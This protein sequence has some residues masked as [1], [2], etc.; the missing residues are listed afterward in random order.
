MAL[1][2]VEGLSIEFQVENEWLPVV[3]D[4]SF[5]LNKGE[6]LALVGESGCGKSVTS[7]SLARLLPEPPARY[8]KGRV[9]LTTDGKKEDILTL[10]PK[11]LRHIRGKRVAYIFQEPTVSLNPVF[12]V[13]SQIA[14]AIELH[15]PEI[16]NVKSE[17]I[18]LL[19]QVGIP[20]PEARFKCYPHEMSG[21]M[22][23]RIMIAIALACQPDILV[24]DEPTTALDV[25][26]QA[27]ILELLQELRETLGMA[28]L[29]ITHN[30]GIVAEVA[31]RV[32]VMYAGK[33][34]EKATT[35]KLL[36]N[37]HHPYTK[38]LLS[39]VPKLD[40]SDHTLTTIRG[41]VPTPQ[42]FPKG[43]RFYGRCELADTLTAE[44]QQKC[45]NIV[46]HFIEVEPE[47][48]AHCHRMNSYE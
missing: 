38:A 43:C 39:A 1:I 30:L 19:E 4:V 47:H 12:T 2:Q 29:L 21:G 6:I 46:P 22:Q 9:L 37:P 36:S 33:I 44:E 25:T 27:Q 10:P 23:Q 5:S 41:G 7:M 24:A 35:D 14:E 20:E 31:D 15:R 42:E 32:L 48:F 13:G 40:E 17:V 26:I 3:T 11:A 16:E 34:L 8:K 45:A 18:K 28:I